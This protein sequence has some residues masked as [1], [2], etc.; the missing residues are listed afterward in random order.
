MAKI[1]IIL[2][3]KGGVGKTFIASTLAQYKIHKGQKPL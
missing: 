1:Q 2:Q 3:G